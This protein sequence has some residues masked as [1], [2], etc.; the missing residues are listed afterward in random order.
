MSEKPNDCG[1]FAIK[2]K[3]GDL[4]YEYIQHSH[5]QIVR[6]VNEGGHILSSPWRKWY[7]A[8]YRIVQ[9][10]IREMV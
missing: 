8:G 6:L 5:R 10:R 1:G 4:Y 7:V 3:D 2:S 9:V